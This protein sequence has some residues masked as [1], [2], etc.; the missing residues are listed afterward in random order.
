MSSSSPLKLKYQPRMVWDGILLA[1][2]IASIVL[3]Q[4]VAA[5]KPPSYVNAG[6]IVGTIDVCLC[7]DSG[8]CHKALTYY[9]RDF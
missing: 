4:L 8:K 7:C 5:I 2:S 9:Y 1:L 3:T 6:Y